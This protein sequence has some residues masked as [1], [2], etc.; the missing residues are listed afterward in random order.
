VFDAWHFDYKAAA[1]LGLG[2][3]IVS[4]LGSIGAYK[5][6]DGKATA[7]ISTG[8]AAAEANT[9]LRLASAGSTGK[10]S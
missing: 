5:L 4:I 6:P 7:V 2:A 1:G 8:A 3:A 10:V 9:A